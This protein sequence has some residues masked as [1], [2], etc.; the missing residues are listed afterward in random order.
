LGKGKALTTRDFA[1]R[2]LIF[3]FL[4]AAAVALWTLREAVL[5]AFFATIIAVGL[6]RPVWLMKSRGFSHALAVGITLLITALIIVLII[7]LIVPDFMMQAEALMEDLPSS[8]ENA[9]NEYN[10]LA[11]DVNILPEIQQAPQITSKDLQEFVT[12]NIG[13]TSRDLFPF[14]TNITAFLTNIFVVIVVAI[15]LLTSPENYIEGILLL[16]PPQHRDRAVDI[17]NKLARNIQLSLGAQ[18]FSMVIV[19]LLTLIGLQIIGIDNSLALSVTAGV[20][21]FVPTFGPIAGYLLAAVVTLATEPEKLFQ[22]TLLYILIQ[23]FE[24][25]FL[26]PRIVRRA[27][28]MPEA[29]VILTQI[30]SGALFGLL[31]FILAVPILA[32]VMTLVEELYVRDTLHT[33][34]VEVGFEEDDEPEVYIKQEM[35]NDNVQD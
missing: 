22:V 32:T 8:I 16:V 2:V 23:Q 31:G 12:E 33:E 26:T 7:V 27:I 24:S 9:T 4:V 3:I 21:E 14:L 29:A 34:R 18:L 30:I 11:S 19:T 6:S 28:K 13:T 10:D 17:L 15:W 25:N 35:L 1:Y 5:L 20:F